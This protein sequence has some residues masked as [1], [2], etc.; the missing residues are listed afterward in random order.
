[1]RSRSIFCPR[2]FAI[3]F[4]MAACVPSLAAQPSLARTVTCDRACLEGMVDKYL[5]A[6][7]AHD[8]SRAPLSPNVKFAQDNVPL[9]IGTA[10]WTTTTALG[11]DRHYFADPKRG[12]VGIIGVIYENDVAAILILR[13]KVENRLITEAEQFVAHDPRGVALDEKMGKP[14]PGWLTTIPPERRQSREALEATAFMYYEALQKNDGRGIYP[15]KSDCSR[16][17]DAV[18]TTNQPKPQNYGHSDEDIS[19]FTM[20]GCKA[21]YEL[22]FLGFTTGCRDRRFL[23]VDTERGSVLASAYLDFDGTVKEVH[24]T[25]GRIGKSALFHDA[26]Y[27]SVE[28]GLSNRKWKH[29]THR[30]DDVRSA[31]QR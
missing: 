28:R 16:I 6:M 18:P 13:L 17:E 5:N 31:I 19:D 23:V 26:S 22:G 2:L 15:F 8:P 12:D 30:N 4:L 27:Q 11:T 21:Q 14:N 10:L 9:K 1:M 20:L 3:L 25:D 24:L 29:S 7:V